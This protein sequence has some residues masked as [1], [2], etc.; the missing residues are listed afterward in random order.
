MRNDIIRKEDNPLL[1]A[2][3]EQKQM[4]HKISIRLLSTIS[5]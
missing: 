4:G 5:E 2:L 3:K 1:V